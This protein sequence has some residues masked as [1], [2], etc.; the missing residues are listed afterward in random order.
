MLL[1]RF[2]KL[3]LKIIHIIYPLPKNHQSHWGKISHL[4]EEILK[5]DALLGFRKGDPNDN[6][7]YGYY[8]AWSTGAGG[9]CL[10]GEQRVKTLIWRLEFEIYIACQVISDDNPNRRLNNLDLE[11]E[12]VIL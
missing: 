12:A 11:M 4:S 9:V 1:G 5:V 8:D 3:A 6:H 7:Y 2:S 10:I